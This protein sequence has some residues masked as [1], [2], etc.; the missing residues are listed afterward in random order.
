VATADCEYP[1]LVVA[2]LNK[3]ISK[4]PANINVLLGRL[5]ENGVMYRLRNG[6]HE[7]SAPKLR[8]YL[9]RRAA[10]EQSGSAALF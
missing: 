1:P 2:N 5:M 9:L 4:T 3:A 8:D 7:Y 10:D 6:H